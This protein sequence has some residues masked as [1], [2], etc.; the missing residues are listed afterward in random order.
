MLEL[1]SEDGKNEN[2]S[3]K[4][5]LGA[6]INSAK[7]FVELN[8]D[9]TLED[10]LNHVA[11]ITDLDA[12]DEKESRVKLM[13]VHAAKGLEFPVVFVV[14]MED[15]L[16]PHANSLFKDEALEE[17]RRACYVALTR[18]ERK[19]Y[20]TA[21]KRRMVFGKA[22]NAKV[23]RFI[24]EMPVECLDCYGYQPSPIKRYLSPQSSYK[25]PTAHR[26]AQVTKPAPK[27][28]S[29]QNNWNVG[30]CVT[31]KKWGSGIITEIAGNDITILF[32][33]PEYGLK[34]LKKNVAPISKI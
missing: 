19:L 25:P 6:F 10:F 14:G 1:T 4:E 29:A 16:F 22:K 33:N 2:E 24:D 15:G 7:E 34:T 30:D 8:S 20:I 13:T 28:F 32:A 12:V 18:A 17:E 27:K 5:N 3:R 31:H 11:L 26:A 9:G 21:A 23:S